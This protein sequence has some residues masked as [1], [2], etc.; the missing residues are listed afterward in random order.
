MRTRIGGVRR[1]V[2]HLRKPVGVNLSVGI[3]VGVGSPSARRFALLN[4]SLADSVIALYDAKYVS[5]DA[6]DA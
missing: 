2:A 5:E 4:L 3:V 1:S 6:T